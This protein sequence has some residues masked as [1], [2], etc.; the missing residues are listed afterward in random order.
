MPAQIE[1]LFSAEDIQ[2]RLAA[3]GHE[4]A[5]E[6]RPGHPEERILV[7]SILRGAFMF[8]A[9]LVRALHAADLEAQVD[10]MWLSSYKDGTKSTGEVVLL[11]ELQVSLEDR[12]VLI[13]D[14][15][16][17]SGRSLAFA[18]QLA[19]DHGAKSVSRCV[20]L[21][22]GE[23]SRADHLRGPMPEFV[24]FD[25]PDLFVVGYGLDWA[26]RYR[27]LPFIGQVIEG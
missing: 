14:D 13:V 20:L 15:I 8:T 24:G 2:T 17:D 1:T 12:T 23:A 18:A 7:L 25:C 6:L 22:K 27:E 5:E 26:G 9:D 4:I 19:K 3:M 21:A 16:Y 11:N 10:F